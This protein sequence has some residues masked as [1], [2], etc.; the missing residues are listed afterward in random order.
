MSRVLC[1]AKPC[2]RGLLSVSTFCRKKF[3]YGAPAS[4]RPSAYHGGHRERA[5]ARPR[6]LGKRRSAEDEKARRPQARPRSAGPG[7]TG[8]KP[9]R[10]L[11]PQHA[12]GVR[13]PAPSPPPMGDPLETPDLGAEGV[14]AHRLQRPAPRTTTRLDRRHAGNVGGRAGSGR[15]RAAAG[16]LS[17]QSSIRT[18]SAEDGSHPGPPDVQEEVDLAGAGTRQGRVG[19]RSGERRVRVP[20]VD[21]EAQAGVAALHRRS[22]A[23]AAGPPAY[24]R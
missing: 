4:A 19:S 14:A 16:D 5:K 7:A 20:A 13:A 12:G 11:R 1:A 6:L 9:H 15:R 17:P 10:R 22:C 2:I 23:A 24:S 8:R 18:P 21:D 3:Q